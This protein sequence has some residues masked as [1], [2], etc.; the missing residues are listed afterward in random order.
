[1][2]QKTLILWLFTLLCWG[3]S[4]VLE[5]IGLK[6]VDPLIALFVRTF[7]ALIGIS[8]F[9]LFFASYQQFKDLSF[10]SLFILGLSGITAGFLGMYFYFSLLKM[11]P[12]SQIVPLTATY[13]LVA[14]LLAIFLLKEPLTLSK[15]LGTFLIVLGIY[16]LFKNP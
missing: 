12:A 9:I 6:K 14:S 1:M 15:L 7:F 11:H 10:K 16:L 13:P 8:F 3:I 4:P 2:D 5:K